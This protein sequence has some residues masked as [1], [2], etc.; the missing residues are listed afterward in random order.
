MYK[1]TG[2][3]IVAVLLLSILLGVFWNEIV[4]VDAIAIGVAIIFGLL[5]LYVIGR[6][7]I[8][9]RIDWSKPNVFVRPF[10][11]PIGAEKPHHLTD[12]NELRYEQR[13]EDEE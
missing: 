3:I 10:L 5:F 1:Y 9:K 11:P 13:Q 12:Q 8:Y 6:S 7:L 4:Q 2:F